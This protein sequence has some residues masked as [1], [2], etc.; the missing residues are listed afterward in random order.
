MEETSTEL[1]LRLM[2]ERNNRI[3]A[4]EPEVLP[5]SLD[6]IREQRQADRREKL[7]Q[8]RARTHSGK[9]PQRVRSILPHIDLSE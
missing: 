4:D 8:L 5:P 1:F 3:A 6:P 9:R 7:G 2:N